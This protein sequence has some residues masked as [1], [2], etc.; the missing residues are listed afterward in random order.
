MLILQM[1]NCI[2][3][4]MIAFGVCLIMRFSWEM[5]QIDIRYNIIRKGVIRVEV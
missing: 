1:W 2:I 4:K 3:C 5:L